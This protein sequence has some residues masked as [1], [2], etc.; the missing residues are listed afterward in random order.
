MFLEMINRMVMIHIHIFK[1]IMNRRV[2]FPFDSL[3]STLPSEQLREPGRL[4]S[5]I[6]TRAHPIPNIIMKQSIYWVDK[7]TESFMGGVLKQCLFVSIKT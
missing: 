3:I 7:L 2:C 5:T 4:K 6:E 1:N